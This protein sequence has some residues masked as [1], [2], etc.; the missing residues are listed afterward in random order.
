MKRWKSHVP[1]M[2]FLKANEKMNNNKKENIA[3]RKTDE[4]YFSY[5]TPN[6]LFYVQGSKSKSKRRSDNFGCDFGISFAI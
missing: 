2:I 6:V 1:E 3:K 5:C 4:D